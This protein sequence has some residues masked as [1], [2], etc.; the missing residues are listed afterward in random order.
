MR[1]IVIRLLLP[2]LLLIGLVVLSRFAPGWQPLLTGPS[3]DVLYAAA[4]DGFRDEWGLY[5]DGQLAAQIEDDRLTLTITPPGDWLPFSLAAPHFTDFDL[6]VTAQALDGPLNNGYGVIF[7]RQAGRER[8]VV[9]WGDLIASRLDTWLLGPAVDSSYYRFMI[10][11]DGYYSLS[12]QIDGR[13][14]MISAWIPSPVINPGFDA[15]NTI[16]VVARGDEFQFFVNGAV[17]PLCIP[18]DPDA[19]ST[20][21]E[22]TGECVEGALVETLADPSIGGGQLGVIAES[23]GEGGVVVAFDD[24]IVRAP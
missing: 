14:R 10:S 23:L 13:E 16:R 2:A 11:S 9:T 19:L 20:Y 12:R 8:P 18:N 21:F 24:L 22:A 7:R 6:T 1:R 3:G 17:M 5:D 4:F 15:P